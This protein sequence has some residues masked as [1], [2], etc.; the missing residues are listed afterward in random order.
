MFRH[1]GIMQECSK[2]YGNINKIACGLCIQVVADIISRWSVKSLGP[3]GCLA[4]ETSWLN[5]STLSLLSLKRIQGKMPVSVQ[6][7]AHSWRSCELLGTQQKGYS[8][9]IVNTTFFDGQDS[10]L[11]D[12]IESSIILQYNKRLVAL[13]LY[14]NFCVY[15]SV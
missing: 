11:E 4:V 1:K 13:L 10:S 2:I 5:L 3:V 9:L 14:I 7:L 8:Q 6:V 15:Y 12:C